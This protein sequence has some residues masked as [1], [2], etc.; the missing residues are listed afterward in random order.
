MP[1]AFDPSLALKPG[2]IAVIT[3][4][5]SGFGRE[6][7]LLCAAAGL[8]LVLADVDEAGLAQTVALTGLPPAAVLAQPCN[9]ADAGEV[10]RLAARAHE[11][12][13]AVHLLFNNAGVIAA[14]PSWKATPQDWQWVFGVN[15]MGVAHGIRSFVPGMLAQGEPAWVVN[16]ASVA[17]L[18]CPPELGVYAASKHAVV[19][20]SECLHH[21]LAGS[22]QPVGVSVLCPAYVDTGIAD[23]F[24]HRP[25]ELA[26]R[27]PDDAAF[28]ARTKVAM[29]AGRLSARDVAQR[30]LD[31]VR[32]GRFYILSHR[33]AAAGVE[34]RLRAF[35]AGG[36]PDNPLAGVG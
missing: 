3:G 31:G 33:S 30:T 35:L 19:A 18:V 2:G 20:L 4:A 14:G 29:Q 27:N 6:L 28:L 25:A 34:S 13:G 5:A 23:A 10:D 9:V 11:R 24:R 15:V 22:G 21:E 17:G 12:F 16:T 32:E 7:A 1:T 26:E 36:A 8:Q